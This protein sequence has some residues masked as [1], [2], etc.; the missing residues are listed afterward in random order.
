MRG[1]N[2]LR[3]KKI[4]CNHSLLKEEERKEGKKQMMSLFNTLEQFQ[5]FT[6]FPVTAKR[7]GEKVEEM[8]IRA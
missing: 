1:K 3:R 7:Q 6:V 5:I 4:V 2:G 8:D